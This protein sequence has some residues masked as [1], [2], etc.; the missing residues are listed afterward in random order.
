MTYMSVV[1]KHAPVQKFTVKNRS[2]PWLDYSL[3]TLMTE[4]DRAKKG[5]VISGSVDDRLNIV[6]YAIKLLN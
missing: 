2:A 3:R 1:N 6:L 4:R 5:S